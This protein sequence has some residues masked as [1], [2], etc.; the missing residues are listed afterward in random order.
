MDD[1]RK[2]Y[3][4]AQDLHNAIMQRDA[5][6]ISEI[7]G[8]YVSGYREKIALAFMEQYNVLPADLF[9]EWGPDILNPL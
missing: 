3:V 4:V 8:R 1:S 9:K 5:I 2:A 6:T 7:T